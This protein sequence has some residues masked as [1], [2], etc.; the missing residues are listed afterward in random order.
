MRIT[1]K[2][3]FNVNIKHLFRPYPKTLCKQVINWYKEKNAKQI[4]LT[5]N[6]KVMKARMQI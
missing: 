4:T 1:N 5:E 3:T 6:S 2:Y